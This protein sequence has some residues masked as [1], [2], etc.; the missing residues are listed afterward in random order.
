MAE[1]ISNMASSHAIGVAEKEGDSLTTVAESLLVTVFCSC[2]GCGM[3]IF[4]TCWM[5]QSMRLKKMTRT[6]EIRLYTRSCV[7]KKQSQCMVS[8]WDVILRNPMVNYY[9]CLRVPLGSH[10]TSP[11]CSGDFRQL[12][13]H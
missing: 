11:W 4:L 12:D 8:C 6:F 9:Q 1:V 3:I 7:L 5:W 10:R 2:L 13:P